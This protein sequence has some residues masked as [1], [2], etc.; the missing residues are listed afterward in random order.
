MPNRLETKPTVPF[1]TKKNTH[2]LIPPKKPKPEPGGKMIERVARGK[3]G[4]Q[5]AKRA[6]GRFR[7]YVRERARGARRA[8]T[9]VIIIAF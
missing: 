8:H 9:L 7:Q 4:K 2:T 1:K 6:R 3:C 5:R